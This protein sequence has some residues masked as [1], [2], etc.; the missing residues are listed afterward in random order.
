MKKLSSLWLS[1]PLIALTMSGCSDDLSNDLEML[2]A[3]KG[4]A[5][6]LISTRPAYGL[7]VSTR[8]E[9]DDSG[10]WAEPE[11][12]E[13][14]PPSEFEDQEPDSPTPSPTDS[15]PQT[16]E[17]PVLNIRTLR[18][19]LADGDGQVVNHHYARLA[20]DN[21]RLTMEGLKA[22]QYSLV[23]LATT[24]DCDNAEFHSPATLSEPWMTN[25]SSCAPLDGGYCFRKV[26]FNIGF[27]QAPVMEQVE[28]GQALARVEVDLHVAQ[29]A[30][31]RHVKKVSVS[32]RQEIPSELNGDGSYSGRMVV[33]HYDIT[34]PRSDYSF[35]TFPSE[36]PV[37]GYIDI[38]S[39]RDSGEDF[40][41]RYAFSG[42]NLEAGRIAHINI[43]YRHPENESGKL[44]VAADQLWRHN[45]KMMFMADE[46]QEVFYDNSIRSFYA[47]A[48][49]QVFLNTEQK[50][51]V[52]LYS[53]IAV[54]KVSVK[55][56]FKK[57]SSEWVDL[58]YL[59][60]VPAFADFSVPMPVTEQEC[61]FLTESGRR[62]RVPAQKSLKA[63]DLEIKIEA[64]DD[65]MRKIAT[66]DSHWYIRFSKYG[67]DSGHQYWRHMDPMLCRHGVA[68]AL[69]MAFMFSS[70]EF[71]D[72]LDT[73]DGILKDNAGNN[74]NLDALRNNIRNH[75]GLNLGRT[76]GVGGLGGG[77]TYGL[78]NYCYTGVY[79]DATA[80]GANPHNYPRQAMFHEYGHCLGYNHNSNMTYGDKWTVLCAKVF[81]EL[82]RAQKLP[83]PNSTDVTSLPF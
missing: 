72:E 12:G 41:T 48:P 13:T 30:I 33:A 18:Y 79:H 81:V 42:L 27:D 49:L 58:A 71:S 73:Y 80:P 76:A 11:E 20:E 1:L 52:K 56:R 75:G 17:E 39:T 4:S 65:F 77:Q 54:K 40:V 44:Y 26:D 31:W 69:N 57:V 43:D 32:F 36:A 74:I 3:P 8:A 47:N 22:G 55:G 19:L 70:Q 82:G 53:P 64:D 67:A 78:A 10:V 46:P 68:L 62:I 61:V 2:N 6:F 16:P 15:V 14:P 24:E 59:E 63:D 25:T 34:D 9:S 83:V 21:S 45:P 60:E 7:D 23:L 66:I 29:P 5:T 35:S 51:Q 50:M 38:E 37:E 28:L